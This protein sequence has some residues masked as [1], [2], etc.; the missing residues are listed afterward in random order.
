MLAMHPEIQ[1]RAFQ[2]IKNAHETQTSHTDAEIIANLDYLEMC[3]KETM[4][5]FPIGP[6]IGRQNSDDIK[7]SM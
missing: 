7:L 5:L 6:F 2:E 4:R 3:I 1:E